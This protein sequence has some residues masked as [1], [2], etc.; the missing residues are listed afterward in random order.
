MLFICYFLLLKYIGE[1]WKKNVIVLKDI[2]EYIT[3]K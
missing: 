2:I 1:T 3:K